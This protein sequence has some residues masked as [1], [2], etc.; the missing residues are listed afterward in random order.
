[1]RKLLI[2]AALLIAV[3]VAA[4]RIAVAVAEN[5]IST[6]VAATYGLPGKPRVAIAGFPFLTQVV[7]GD[8]RQV[9]VHA[10]GVQAGGAT[11]SWLS[12][13]LT[14]VHASLPQVL[15]QGAS[16]VT[17]RS[18]TGSALIGFTELNQRLPL[19]VRLSPAGHRLRVS[20]TLDEHGVRL[21]VSAAVAV[22][23]TPVGIRIAAGAVRTPGG[24]LPAALA[25]RYLPRLSFD[26][27]LQTL[28]L[29]LRVTSVAVTGAGLWIGAS[30]HDVHFAAG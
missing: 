24:P 22:R 13:S 11:L 25:R 17:A 9:S 30:A 20:G 2:A 15:G 18:A 27:P 6:R 12:A 29:H 1:M 19:G 3:L 23:V 5:Q 4:D 7:T 26:I 21:P 8:Y 10:T 16:L 28:P 14:G